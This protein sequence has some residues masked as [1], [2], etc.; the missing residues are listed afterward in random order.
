LIFSIILT[1]IILIVAAG[2]DIKTGT[3]PNF[4]T[5]PAVI[6]GL[7]LS[8]VYYGGF[9][10]LKESFFGAGLGL[11]L[12]VIPFILGGIGGGD[13]K[14]MAAIGALNGWEFVLYAFLYSAVVGGIMAAAISLWNKKLGQVIFN[15]L[16][17][18]TTGQFK[19]EE[20]E[21]SPL[22]SGLSFP[23]GIAIMIGTCIAYW[24]RYRGGF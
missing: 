11:L 5:I 2:W 18:F 19:I 13:V 3:I 8:V 15:I 7:L 14:L 17:Q 23:Y 12:L 21:K 16:M 6:A 22:S 20:G 24:F 4:I 9:L 10:G 1:V